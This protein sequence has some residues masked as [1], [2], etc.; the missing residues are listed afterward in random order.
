MY[1]PNHTGVFQVP[2]IFSQGDLKEMDNSKAGKIYVQAVHFLVHGQ[3][4]IK[5]LLVSDHN[6]DL[7][8][9]KESIKSNILTNF[10]FR[11]DQKCEL[12]SIKKDFTMF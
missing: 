8:L 7:E 12:L 1:L 2:T 10:S 4:K 3:V 6:S 11:S 9:A 5:F